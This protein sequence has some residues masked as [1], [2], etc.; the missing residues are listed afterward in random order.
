M[1]GQKLLQVALE[2]PGIQRDL[3]LPQERVAAKAVMVPDRELQCPCEQEGLV[4]LILGR[5][6]GKPPVSKQCR[7]GDGL[8]IHHQPQLLS[9]EICG[10]TGACNRRLFT[11]LSKPAETSKSCGSG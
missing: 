10:T 3:H 6:T 5:E 1:Q 4:N 9:K 7:A 2:V 11:F 8:G